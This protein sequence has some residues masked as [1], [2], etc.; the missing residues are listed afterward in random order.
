M[1][2]NPADCGNPG[3]VAWWP[4]FRDHGPLWKLPR[5]CAALKA[6]G[7]RCD[8]HVRAMRPRRADAEVHRAGVLEAGDGAPRRAGGGRLRARRGRP[9]TGRAQQGRNRAG[10]RD[11]G[12]GI[13]AAENGR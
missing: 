3:G 1:I 5:V 11:G 9:R 8:G 13:P 2:E 10:T 7:R 6:T 4:R 12:R